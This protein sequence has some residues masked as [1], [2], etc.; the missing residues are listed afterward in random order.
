MVTMGLS[1]EQHSLKDGELQSRG[2]IVATRILKT[3]CKNLIS[4]N[5]MLPRS[6]HTT[7]AIRV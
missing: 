6:S 2:F 5:E 1:M 4:S 7:I 3:N